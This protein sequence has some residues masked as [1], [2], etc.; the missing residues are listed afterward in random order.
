MFTYEE[1]KKGM[2]KKKKIVCAAGL[3]VLL[4]AAVYLGGVLYFGSHFCPGTSIDGIPAGGRSAE[5]VEVLIRKEIDQYSIKLAGREGAE[6]T[7]E[8]SSIGLAPVFAG[9]VEALLQEQNGFAWP[10]ALFTE[11]QLQL[12]R[13]VSYDEKALESALDALSMTKSANQRRPVDASCSPYREGEGYSLISADYGTTL[14]RGVLAEKVGEAVLVLSD[15]I[16]LDESGCYVDPEVP[17]DDER[18]LALLEELNLYAGT[19]ITYDFGENREILDGETI[20]TWLSGDNW[21]VTVDEEKVLDFVKT[22]AKKYN[23]AYQKKTLKTSYGQEITISGGHYGWRIDNAG[24]TEQIL[25]DLKEGKETEREPVYLQTAN[26]HGENDYGDSYVEI[27]LTA[28]HLFLYKNGKLVIESDFVSGN[29]SKGNASPTGAFSLTYKTTDAVLRGEDYATPVKYWMPFAGDVGMHD[30]S[31]RSSFGGSIYKT[32]GSHGCINMPPSA[33]K[34]VYENIDKGYA[35]LVYTLPG[36]ES[37]AALQQDAAAVVNAINAIGTVTPESEP[38]IANARNL[39]NALSA[40]AKPYVSNYDV[41]TAAEAALAQLKAGMQPPQ[42][43]APQ[44]IPPQEQ[45]PQDI[46]PQEPVPEMQEVQPEG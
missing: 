41:L 28:Q 43:Q 29:V 45:P 44:D 6:E 31:W 3:I 16:D 7:I 36:T 8:G 21:E 12:D 18:L 15:R 20:S 1:R 11:T 10:A 30:A 39:Y 40:E 5:E 42:E 26:S 25:A 2:K 17:D 38:A 27:N 33:A 37:K 4:M 14:N 23:T 19:V 46:P 13:V 35:V 9:E 22:L 34:T 24:E 32:G